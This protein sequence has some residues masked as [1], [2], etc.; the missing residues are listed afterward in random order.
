MSV[1]VLNS[2]ISG[3]VFTLRLAD[4]RSLQVFFNRGDAFTGIYRVVNSGNGFTPA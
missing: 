1:D 2:M 3:Q 4:N